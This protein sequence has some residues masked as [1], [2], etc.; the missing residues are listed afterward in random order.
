[1]SEKHKILDGVKM[2]YV[3][4]PPWERSKRSGAV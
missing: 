2:R 4:E 3:L 1:M